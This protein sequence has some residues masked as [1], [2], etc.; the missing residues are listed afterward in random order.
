MWNVSNFNFISIRHT[1]E[2][3]QPF[4]HLYKFVLC[5]STCYTDFVCLENGTLM[6]AMREVLESNPLCLVGAQS[7]T[8]VICQQ[9][10]L[11]N[12]LKIGKLLIM[13]APHFKRIEI[14]SL[15]EFK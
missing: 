11:D 7:L 3:L 6:N 2:T 10:D 12:F 1:E 14:R 8:A 13:R 15:M 9:T 4:V 5:C